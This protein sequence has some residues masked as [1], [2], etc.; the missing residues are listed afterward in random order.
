[1]A[2]LGVAFA[3]L[4]VL[5]AILLP[6]RGPGLVATTGLVLVVPV[7]AGAAVGGFAAGAVSV[8]AGFGVYDYE[9]IAPYGT[10]EVARARDWAPLGVYVVVLL[11][12]TLVVARMDAARAEAQRRAQDNRRLLDLSEMLVAGRALDT[13]L[14]AVVEALYTSFAVVGAAVLLPQP[15]GGG[16]LELVASAGQAPADDDL[17]ALQGSAHLPVGIGVQTL[18]SSQRR[19][20]THADGSRKAPSVTS[21]AVALTVSGRPI[22]VLLLGRMPESPTDRAVLGAFANHVAL[23]IERAQLQQQ[24]TRAQILEET[25][26]VRHGLL[27]AVSHD[28][29]TPL[30]TIKAAASGLLDPALPALPAESRELLELVDA[31]ADRLDRMVSN[32]L[33]MTRVETG[34]LRVDPEPVPLV[35][36]V[37]EAVA[38]LGS[39]VSAGRVDMRL[40]AGLPL[41][42]VDPLLIRQVLANLIE[43]ALRHGPESTPVVVSAEATKGRIEVSVLDEGPGVDPAER[44][45]VFDMWNRSSAGGREG[46]GLAIAKT[47]IE[48]HGERIWVTG[49]RFVFTLPVARIGVEA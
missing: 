15:G 31:Q 29:R 16:R 25:E 6:F 32:L 24:A 40:A 47:F 9:F 37:T 20:A 35:D 43:N 3:L 48:A 42:E 1:M 5:T 27:G 7:V 11:L 44:Q 33:D 18:P 22:G 39:S 26:A 8:A 14:A 38:T 45:R 46:L 34:Q 2:G 17:K 28:L 23:A 12:V 19:R 13:L 30:S 41:V 49:A 10:F 4:A 21:R 36:L